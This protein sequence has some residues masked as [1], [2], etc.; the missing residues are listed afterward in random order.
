MKALIDGDICVYRVGFGAEDEAEGIA[1]ARMDE[2]VNL[3]LEAVHA[4]GRS[5]YLTSGDKSNF[6]HTIFPDYKANRKAPK[7]KHYDLLRNHLVN[8]HAAELCY[9]Q[10]ADDMLGIEATRITE[11]EGLAKCVICSIDKD[12]DQIPGQHYNFVKGIL[13]NI[14]PY[15]GLLK[16]YTQ[17]LMGDATD[18]IQGI[19][20]IGPKKAATALLGCTSEGDMYKATLAAYRAVYGKEAMEKM[21]LFG[22]LLK[23][24][25]Q[26]GELW[27]HPLN[28]DPV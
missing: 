22:Q 4:T 3:I 25:T 24:R 16:F 1:C 10:E 28:I 7:P 17:L 15:E 18:N 19:P 14:N 26:Q 6:R 8:T 27:Q 23:I 12:L 5:I 2:S 13:Y 11:A 9:G 20:G 21:L